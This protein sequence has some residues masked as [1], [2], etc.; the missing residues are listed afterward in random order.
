MLFFEHKGLYAIKEDVPDGEIVDTLGSAKVLR[1]GGDATIVALAAMV[2]RALAAAEALA[3]R[4]IDATVVDVRCLVPLD[5][6]TILREVSA[7]GAHVHRRGEPAP[8]RVGCGARVDR[9]RGVLQ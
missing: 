4:G 9:R 6:Q 7:S 2:P 8:V 3:G 1:T 5:T